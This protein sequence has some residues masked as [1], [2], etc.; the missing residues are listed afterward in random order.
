[1]VEGRTTVVRGAW[2]LAYEAGHP[3]LRAN[4]S[5]V[6]EGRTIA[7]VTEGEPPAADLRLGGSRALVIPGFVNL[8]S[9]C[10][11]APLFRG[12]VDDAGSSDGA[13]GGIYSLLMPVGDLAARELSRE[14]YGDL[15]ALGMLEA[16]K[17]GSTTLLDMWRTEQDVFFDVAKAFGIRAYACPYL[18]STRTL[19]LGPDGQPVYESSGAADDGGLARVLDLHRRFD[20]DAQGRIRVAL[21][22]HGTD[23]CAPDLLRAVREAA[24]RLGCRVSIHLAQSEL[25]EREIRRRYGKGPVE[26]LRHVGL[27]GSDLVAAHCV[28]ASDADL[29]ILRETGTHVA[30]CAR[31][32]ARGGTMAAYH[33][34]ASHGVHTGIGTDSPSM[35]LLGELRAAGFVSKLQAGA[36]RAAPAQALLDAGTTAGADALGRPDLGRIAPGARA[37]LL[38][39]DL[40]RPHLQSVQDPIKTLVWYATPSDISTVM[41][42]GELLVHEGRLQRGDEV[43]I[44]DRGRRSAEKVWDLAAR[45]GLVGRA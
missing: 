45:R 18:F 3:V 24:D 37:D 19:K 41:V 21:G 7:A 6:V 11:N 20:G 9:H 30:S 14:E 42:D 22:P 17:G 39:V 5:V 15:V 27:L 28:Y 26:Y 38:V 8:H 32:Y 2:V 16:L 36:S 12:I 10:V 29:A 34:F 23:S 1:M 35:D 44:A 4:A 13:S 33:R 25:E 43:A 40:A 31:V